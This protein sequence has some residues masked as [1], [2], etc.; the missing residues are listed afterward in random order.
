[1]QER[2]GLISAVERRLL[3]EVRFPDAFGVCHDPT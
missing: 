1:M 2:A 3:L